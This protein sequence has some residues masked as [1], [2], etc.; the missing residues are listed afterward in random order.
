LEPSVSIRPSSV[1]ALAAAAAAAVAILP[2]ATAQAATPLPDVKASFAAAQVQL[3]T[4]AALVTEVTG[5]ANSSSWAPGT[6]VSVTYPTNARNAGCVAQTVILDAARKARFTCVMTLTKLG[7]QDFT[8]NAAGPKAH[9]S[10][11]ATVNV[12][13]GKP[14]PAPA[15][16]PTKPPVVSTPVVST[17]VVLPVPAP[18][19]TTPP[20]VTPAPVPAPTTSRPGAKNT[21]VPAGVQLKA[22]GALTITKNGTVIDGLHIKG[23]VKVNADN[24][25]IRNSIIDS[26][27]LYPVQIDSANK[28]LLIEDTE[29][30]GNGKASV[31]I[32]KGNYT[33][34]RL[35][36]HDVKDGPRIEGDNVLI[37]NSWIHT[38]TRVEGGHHDTI[39]IRKG[40]NIVLRGNTLEAYKATTKDPMN[41]AIQ[42]GSALGDIPVSGLLVEN[43]YMNG[44]NYT[45]NGGTY[46][47]TQATYRGN[48]FGRDF[49][50]GIVT[51]MGSGSTFDKTNVFADTAQPVK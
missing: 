7:K 39:Q 38:L 51:N 15:P 47:V 13:V 31:A 37:E 8:I 29:I 17:P 25:T 49:R 14:A 33:L 5:P 23:N 18:A 30:D 24:V 20:V 16:A 41:A 21:G 36:I 50:Y 2:A 46:W 6:P 10:A 44:G 26:T 1:V 35:N 11:T 28:G 40:R 12:I 48:T 4:A 32:L 34:R 9:R 22:S 43:N 42:I 45:I 27:A 3:N 19:Q